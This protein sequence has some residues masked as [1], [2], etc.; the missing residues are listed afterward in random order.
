MSQSVHIVT[1]SFN[2]G[3]FLKEC[4]DSVVCK[5]T[6]YQLHHHILDN[7]SNDSTL[8]VISQYRSKGAILHFVSEKDKGPAAA[9]NRGF[10]DALAAG[11]TVIGWLNADDYY[12]PEAIAR[13]LQAFEDNPKLQFVYGHGRHIDLQGN[14]LGAYPSLPPG[15]SLK[16]FLNG[17][18]ICQPTVFF[19]AEVLAK[20]GFLDETLQTAFDLDLWLRVFK[21]Y[22]SN[23]ISFINKVM[24]Y[25]RL[26]EQCLTNRLRETVAI[27][28]MQVIKKH[29]APAPIHW[30]QTYFEE[31]CLKYPFI[32]D[33]KPLVD[34]V[35]QVLTKAKGL[36]D[37]DEFQKLVKALE[38]DYR[39]RFSNEQVSLQIESDGWV[40]KR[41][42]VKLRYEKNQKRTVLLRCQ[43]GWPS[44]GHIHLAIR[45]DDGSI[46][47]VK[48]N[49][50][51]EFVLTLE[52]P[53]TQLAAYAIWKIETRQYFVPSQAQKPSKDHR[54]LSFRV[55]GLALQ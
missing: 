24:A 7:C 22:K 4:L 35:K 29:I 14:D 38:A 20:V 40:S 27:E 3:A 19:R 12:A 21:A 1:P 25:S 11:A 34:L 18:F 13:A 48:L 52:A 31:L 55:D 37:A 8:A 9:I 51:D 46:E 5:K 2:S 10:R 50:Q 42:I 32:D 26:H 33:K 49:S 36:V 47:K 16:N 44:M 43:G 54:Q 41:L 28:S 30:V 23:Q 53:A 15:R 45:A 17:C 39:L 6:S